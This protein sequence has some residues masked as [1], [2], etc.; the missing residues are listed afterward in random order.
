MENNKTMGVKSPASG[1]TPPPFPVLDICNNLI[2]VSSY[3]NA[4]YNA[5]LP[6]S[7]VS[8]NQQLATNFQDWQAEVWDEYLVALL[9]EGI[10]AEALEINDLIQ[11]GITAQSVYQ[12]VFNPNAG[13]VPTVIS[14]CDELTN[15]ITS[16]TDTLNSL[17]AVAQGMQGYD[18]GQMA[19]LTS[20]VNSLNTQFDSMEDQ[21][22]EKALENMKEV[23]V[24]IVEVGVAVATEEDPI[25]PL[26]NGVAQVGENLVTELTL[27]SAINS[28][29]SDLETA[30]NELDT[31][32]IEYAI[33]TQ[34]INKLNAVIGDATVTVNALNN[35]V[36]DWQTIVD[37]VN[38]PAS[39]WTP[40]TF[41]MLQEWAARMNQISWPAP[42]T[43]IITPS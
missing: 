39:S 5:T 18:A 9:N 28:T 8:A 4:V 11:D 37:A 41:P 35:I 31:V 23:V 24:T 22:T 3:L 36:N 43:Q 27:S 2:T 26:I 30:W 19:N 10:L 13:P 17:V 14:L 29:L 33:V 34:V 20:I 21:L 1:T 40:T 16:G 25:S 15:V 6:P 38:G 7:V 32:T 12:M 42:V